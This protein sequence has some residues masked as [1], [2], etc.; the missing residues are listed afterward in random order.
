MNEL[1]ETNTIQSLIY[2]IR[3][4]RVMLDSDLAS[5]YGVQTKRLN[6]SVKRNIKRFPNDFMFQLTKEE[7]QNL[8]SQFATFKSDS[9]KYL[10][11]VFTE[12][13]VTMLASVLNSDKAIEINIQVV[14]AFISLRQYILENNNLTK[15]LQQLQVLFLKA[16]CLVS[17]RG[18]LPQRFLSVLFQK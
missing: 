11:Y 4:K 13:G 6:Q 9:R 15:Q 14:R 16:H 8:R 2:I 12:H 17:G 7:W 5:L 18:L 1:I 10:P 3:G